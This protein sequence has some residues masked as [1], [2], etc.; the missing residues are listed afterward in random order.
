MGFPFRAVLSQTRM[1]TWPSGFLTYSLLA[2]AAFEARPEGPQVNERRSWRRSVL[3][4][5]FT[6]GDGFT[7]Q[8]HSPEPGIVE[9]WGQVSPRG[10]Q[11]TPQAFHAVSSNEHVHSRGEWPGCSLFK[12]S[13]MDSILNGSFPSSW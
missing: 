8:H 2:I 7:L 9:G 12:P 10:I 3:G 5:T 6:V 11:Y 13:A 4:Y 1:V